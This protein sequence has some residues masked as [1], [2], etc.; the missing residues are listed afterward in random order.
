MLTGE[1]EEDVFDVGREEIAVGEAEGGVE[2]FEDKFCSGPK[3]F[4]QGVGKGSPA[5]D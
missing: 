2:S 5:E 4:Q 1:A 3:R